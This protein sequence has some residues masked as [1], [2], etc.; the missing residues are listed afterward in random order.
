MKKKIFYFLISLLIILCVIFLSIKGP[1]YTGIGYI[2]TE[3]KILNYIKITEFYERHKNYKKLVK[4]IN[5][6]N[7]KKDEQIINISKWVYENIK[8]ISNNDTVIDSHPWTIVER[9]RGTIDQF[10]DILSVLLTHNNVESFFNIN[11]NDTSHPFTFFKYNGAWSIIDPYYGVYFLNKKNQFCNMYEHKYK[12]CTLYHLDYGEIT[13]EQLNKIYFDK[14]FENMNNFNA[15]YNFLLK[16][17]NK[18]EKIDET[19]VYD[20]GG[21][22]YIQKPIHRLIFQIRNVISD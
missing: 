22:S 17:L 3:E 4:K 2:I 11:L 13:N 1:R 6:N 7:K 8:K 18:F 19:S 10:S 21:R 15:Y 14:K 12:K 5:A 16:N 20:R 9:R